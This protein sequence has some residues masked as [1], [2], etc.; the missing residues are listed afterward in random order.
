MKYVKQLFLILFISFLGEI[1]K[2]VL[3]FPVPASIY[4]LLILFICLETGWLKLGSVE[5]TA[6]YLVEIM[7]LMFIPAGVGLLE[8][9]GALQPVLLK[10]A[11]ITVI[12]TI[13]VMI[14]AG[15]V[16]Q[17]IIRIRR[18]KEEVGGHE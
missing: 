14:A 15:R 2:Y 5:E 13:V 9:W 6:K 3:P 4:G 18:R 12:S 8:S 7:P 17:C 11:V 1:L 10:I 16:T